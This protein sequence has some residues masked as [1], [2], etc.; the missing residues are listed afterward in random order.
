MDKDNLLTDFAGGA[1]IV[2]GL[3]SLTESLLQAEL[4]GDSLPMVQGTV[5]SLFAISFGGVLMT[6]SATEAFKR[7]RL[8]CTEMLNK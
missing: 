5:V 1:I 2:V 7:L 4:A 3:V 6:E 8:R